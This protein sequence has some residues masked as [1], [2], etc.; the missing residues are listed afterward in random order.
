MPTKHETGLFMILLPKVPQSY[1][2]LGL[3]IDRSYMDGGD[4]GGDGWE[5]R[6]MVRVGCNSQ[7]N[8]I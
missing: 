3:S 5:Q 4:G 7:V 1:Q 6:Q 2:D 8:L